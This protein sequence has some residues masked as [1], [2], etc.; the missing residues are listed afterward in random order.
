[1]EG[2]A[3]FVFPILATGLI[4]FFVSAAVTFFNIG[5]RSDFV[6]RWLSGFAIGWPIA[7]LI[8]V[9]AFPLLRR[10]TASVVG[11]IERE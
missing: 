1:M 4:V 6:R 8:A 3:R 10:V 5:F 9:L 2:K 7:A 11:L